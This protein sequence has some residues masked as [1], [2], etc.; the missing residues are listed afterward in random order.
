[1]RRGAMNRQRIMHFSM[2]KGMKIVSYRQVFSH[3][4]G[5]YQQLGQ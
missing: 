2:E 3:I 5:S 4:R 1:V